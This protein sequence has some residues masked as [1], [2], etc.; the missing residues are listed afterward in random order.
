MAQNS[1][2]TAKRGPGR[3]FKPGESGN[4][5][6]RPRLTPE[7]V[8]LRDLARRHTGVAIEALVQILKD[9]NAPASSRVAA[10]SEI[11]DRGWGRAAAT[12]EHSGHV[13]GALPLG[14]V[15]IDY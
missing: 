6:G 10:A 5:G 9:T 14:D 13:G 7:F 1:Q 11:F 8:E 12:L 3:P 4:P 15:E 2:Q